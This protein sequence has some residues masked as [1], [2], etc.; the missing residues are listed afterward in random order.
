MIRKMADGTAVDVAGEK[1]FTIGDAVEVALSA[2]FQDIGIGLDDS[3]WD[4]LVRN[5]SSEIRRQLRK[6][7]VMDSDI[8]LV[9]GGTYNETQ[10]LLQRLIV[11][12]LRAIRVALESKQPANGKATRI[13]KEQS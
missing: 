4:R 5:A 7:G 12:E 3:R 11:Q 9:H 10:V 1:L 6:V 8:Q 13:V 2:A